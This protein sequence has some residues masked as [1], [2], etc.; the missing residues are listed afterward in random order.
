MTTIVPRVLVVDD[1][2][3]LAISLAELL[4]MLGCEAGFVHTGEDAIR[5][6]SGSEYHL[7]LMDVGLPDI[8]GIAA[9]TSIRDAGI[10]SEVLL[11]SGYNIEEI[12]AGTEFELSGILLPKPLDLDLI[13]IRLEAIRTIINQDR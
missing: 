3:E 10:T 5:E 6:T 12:E 9:M 13:T 2:K 8:D 7:I 1:D 4:E 11:M